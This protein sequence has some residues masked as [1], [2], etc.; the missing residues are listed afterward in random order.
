MVGG[1]L[2]YF[3]NVGD[4]EM[5]TLLSQRLVQIAPEMGEFED[6]TKVTSYSRLSGI[7]GQLIESADES[8]VDS[9]VQA[10]AEERE[11]FVGNSDFDEY[12]WWH[13]AFLLQIQNDLDRLADL[14]IGPL[15]E[16][17]AHND[18]MHFMHASSVVQAAQRIVGQSG[19]AE[20]TARSILSAADTLKTEL[21]MF[22]PILAAH[23]MLGNEDAIRAVLEPILDGDAERTA[24]FNPWFYVSVA[25]V[26]PDQAA[27]LLLA[28]K[29][30]HP[31]WP[32]TSVIALNHVTA[33]HLLTHP[34][35]QAFYVEQ[36]KWIPYLAKRVPEYAQYAQ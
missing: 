29:A 7:I 32:G 8:T 35:M 17:P 15:A 33:R 28:H 5:T 26:D 31:D 36:G 1:A 12:L 11:N 6:L 16:N 27:E 21:S 3:R 18:V 34:A 23:A 10:F 22:P 4:Q 9:Y 19:R 14:V 2:T 30:E 20:N 13:E 24:E 25:L